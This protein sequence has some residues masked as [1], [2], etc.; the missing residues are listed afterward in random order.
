MNEAEY[1]KL[2]EL[3]L[4]RELTPREIEQMEQ[5]LSAHPEVRERW[6]I[7][8]RLNESLRDLPPVEISPGFTHRVLKQIEQEALTR[9]PVGTSLTPWQFV[10]TFALKWARPAAFVAVVAVGGIAVLRNAQTRELAA[11]AQHAAWFAT[12]AS[13]PSNTSN[14][15]E[16]TSRFDGLRD[17]HVISLLPSPAEIGIRGD[18]ELL[19]ALR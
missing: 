9:E 2:V 13:L 7:D 5:L 16:D 18:V 11:Q 8:C 4:R 1:L 12:L 10:R 19:A 3:G 15:S 14:L 6:Q 17:Y